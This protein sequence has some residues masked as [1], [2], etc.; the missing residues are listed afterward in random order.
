MIFC[1]R[2][3]P[4]YSPPSMTQVRSTASPRPLLS[5]PTLASTISAG[6]R[7]SG[8]RPSTPASFSVSN[9]VVSVSLMVTSPSLGPIL[10]EFREVEVNRNWH[11]R[12]NTKPI[13]CRE[14]WPP[15]SEEK[16]AFRCRSSSAFIEADVLLED[17]NIVGEKENR[18][19]CIR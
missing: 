7:P 9:G 14:C 8:I 3:R 18:V 4:S 13:L 16:P 10:G 5:D 15:F 6:Y 2:W 17:S 12:G 19:H 1:H 11:L